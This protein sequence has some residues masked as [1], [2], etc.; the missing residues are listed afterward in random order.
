MPLRKSPTKTTNIDCN[1]GSCI[2]NGPGHIC[3]AD[4]S[5]WAF[6]RVLPGRN[7]MRDFHGKT[8]SSTDKRAVQLI[9]DGKEPI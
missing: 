3:T 6:Q 5:G 4:E 8:V 7:Q 9:F 1:V 2:Y